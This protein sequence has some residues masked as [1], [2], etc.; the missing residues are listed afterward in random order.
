M[1]LQVKDDNDSNNDSNN[2]SDEEEKEHVPPT[3]TNEELSTSVLY[4]LMKAV[5]CTSFPRLK[6][7]PNLRERRKLFN[8]WQSDLAIIMSTVTLTKDIFLLWPQEI[9]IVP[10][11]VNNALFNL[12]SSQCEAGPKA[13]IH[14]HHGQGTKAITELQ[15]HYAQITSKII[16]GAIKHYQ[17][18]NQQ[19]NETAMSYMQCF[20][21][22]GNDCQQ[23]GENFNNDEL[24]S[25]F[26]NGLDIMSK[27]TSHILNH[28]MQR[29]T[30]Q[31]S[32]QCSNQ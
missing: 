27:V 17:Q 5:K 20:D 16:E 13:H 21:V 28:C 25:Q 2:D 22:T 7:S 32:T 29:R 12:I 1:Q 4:K 10:N 23:L 8:A 24:L 26:M 3:M 14:A 30:W 15:H 6:A 18:M 11:Y 9:G 31:N 19:Q